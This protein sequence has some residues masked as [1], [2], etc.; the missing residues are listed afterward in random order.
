MRKLIDI[1]SS[2]KAGDI[3]THDECYY[4][5][6][7]VESLSK[8]DGEALMQLAFK[9]SKFLTPG[10]QHAESFRRHKL[11]LKKSPLEWLGPNYDPKNP[12][13]QKRVKAR[14]RI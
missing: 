1:I 3:P 4:A 14:R 10:R 9:P 7:A 2:A 8:F 5:L 11:A 12:D 6:L 13:V